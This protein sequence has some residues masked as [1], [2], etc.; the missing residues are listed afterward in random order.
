MH[1][2]WFRRTF[3]RVL[4]FLEMKKCGPNFWGEPILQNFW[5]ICSSLLYFNFKSFLDPN[6]SSFI[7]FQSFLHESGVLFS[8]SRNFCKL[9][10]GDLISGRNQ[11]CRMSELFC[12][13]LYF[14]LKSYMDPNSS[15]FSSFQSFLHE[16]GIL[17]SESWNF[18]KLR[19]RDLISK[20]NQFW[21][22]SQLF[23]LPF[24]I[25]IL[26]VLWTLIFCDS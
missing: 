26:E 22:M 1:A 20:G 6:Y 21:R 19:S 3:P 10:T 4:I 15:L 7:R 18:C 24:F 5:I 12:P 11:F 2:A 23:G 13:L 14:N 17:F 9:K 8:R 16:T 25:S